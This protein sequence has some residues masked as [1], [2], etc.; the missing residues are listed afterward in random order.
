MVPKVTCC[1]MCLAL[2]YLMWS[3]DTLFLSHMVSLFAAGGLH[4]CMWPE[5]TGFSKLQ[6]PSASETDDHSI[7]YVPVPGR[8]PSQGC[9]SHRSLRTDLLTFLSHREYYVW[10]E[11][12]KGLIVNCFYYAI[13]LN[14]FVSIFLVSISLIKHVCNFACCGRRPKHSR[15][16]VEPIHDQRPT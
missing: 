7:Y 16:T 3:E 8:P 9:P 6:S 11:P 14:P 4:S 5:A 12:V 15:V 13:S 1:L 10:P 2:L